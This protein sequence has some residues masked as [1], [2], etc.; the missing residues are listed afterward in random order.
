MAGASVGM[1]AG[2]VPVMAMDAFD[3]EGYC[4]PFRI[5]Q[6]TNPRIHESEKSINP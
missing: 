3:V 6:F 1:P 2:T 4:P 5:Y